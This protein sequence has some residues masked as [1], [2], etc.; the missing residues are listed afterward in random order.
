MREECW[1]LEELLW[2]MEQTAVR[3]R[4]GDDYVPIPPDGEMLVGKDV[5]NWS[6]RCTMRKFPKGSK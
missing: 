1:G 5:R 6:A 2:E 4:R 3:F